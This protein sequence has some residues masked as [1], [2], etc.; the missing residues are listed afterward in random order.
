M[1]EE[2]ARQIAELN[3]RL[4]ADFY[5]PAFGPRP[6]PGHI[7]CTRG[8][9]DLPPETQIRASGRKWRISAASPRTTIPTGKHDFGAFDVDGTE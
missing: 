4:C 8:V 6:V 9:A 2:K 7:T 5:I 1:S 3:H